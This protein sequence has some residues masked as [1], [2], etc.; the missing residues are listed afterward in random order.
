MYI[1]GT[2]VGLGLII[3][4]FRNVDA[5]AIAALLRRLEFGVWLVPI[6]FALGQVTETLAW[7]SVFERV[8]SRVSYA[9]LLRIRLGCEGI[10]ATCPGGVL[11]AESIKPGLLMRQFGLTADQAICGT[12]ARKYL[13]LVSQCFYFGIAALLGIP[14]LRR[15]AHATEQGWWLSVAVI[16]AFL[17]LL[18]AAMGATLLFSRSHTCDQ[19]HRWLSRFPSE[20]ARRALARSRTAFEKTGARLTEFYGLGPRGLAQPIALYLLAWFWEAFETF[21]LLTLLGVSL[22]V[23]TI[24][25]IEVCASM[26]RNIAFLS[27]SGLGAQDLGY[28]GLLQLFAVPNALSLA[29]AFLLLKRAKELVW[30]LIGY[31]LLPGLMVEKGPSAVNWPVPEMVLTRRRIDPI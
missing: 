29:V 3:G 12:A 15:V 21:T 26:V 11:I 28:A 1:W 31:G 8:H 6:P 20:K 27:P 18:L 14:A 30:S 2:V 13:L 24:L 25:L 22:D 17:A 7:K 9:R 4:A 5:S 19:L 16:V 23:G 10:T